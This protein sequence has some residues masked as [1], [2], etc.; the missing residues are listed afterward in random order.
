MQEDVEEESRKPGKREGQQERL[1]VQGKREKINA[2]LEKQQS[3]TAVTKSTNR[4]ASRGV[5]QYLP[6]K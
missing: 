5:Q 2:N 6:L 1:V 4:N 3:V